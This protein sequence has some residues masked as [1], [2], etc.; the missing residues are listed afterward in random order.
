VFS[1]FDLLYTFTSGAHLVLWCY[2]SFLALPPLPLGKECK[3]EMYTVSSS[4][5]VSFYL[6]LLFILLLPA[7]EE[8]NKNRGKYIGGVLRP[9][10]FSVRCRVKREQH[11]RLIQLTAILG[12][13]KKKE[14]MSKSII[15]IYIEREE[16]E[17]KMTAYIYRKFCSAVYNDLSAC[18]FR[19]VS[20]TPQWSV[21]LIISG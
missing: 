6:S 2:S 5:L 11:L 10:K 3:I 17:R 18:N 13:T 20:L 8:N 9:W 16:L 14:R 15:Y 19:L 21:S 1:L 12:I 4:G 7:S